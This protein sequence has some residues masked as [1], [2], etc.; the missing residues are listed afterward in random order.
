MKCRRCELPILED[1]IQ[2]IGETILRAHGV[3]R[4]VSQEL[5]LAL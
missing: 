5:S 2:G 4:Y 1:R 3:M